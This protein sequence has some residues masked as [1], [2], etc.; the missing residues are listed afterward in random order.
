MYHTLF[1]VDLYLSL[2][3]E[4]RD[5]YI[6]KFKQA[7]EFR[8][9]EKNFPIKEWEEAISRDEILEYIK[10]L[11]VKTQQGFTGLNFERLG[12]D[13]IFE[14]HGS[15][16]ISS[17]LYNLR[18]MMLHIGALQARLRINGVKGRFWVSRSSIVE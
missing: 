14:W 3:K 15:S 6:P 9:S 5:N 16:L 11:R 7:D 12:A 4:E 17:L 2:T 10:D 8:A 18:H 1:Y 13:P